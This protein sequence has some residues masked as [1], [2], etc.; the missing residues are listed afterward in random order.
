MVRRFWEGTVLGGY[1]GHGETYMHPDD[2]LWWAKGGTL[3]GTSPERIAFLRRVMEE[4]PMMGMDPVARGWDDTVIGQDGSYY[5]QYFGIKRPSFRKLDYLP[6]GIAFEVDIIDTWEMTIT[7]AEGRYSKG[8]ALM[9]PAKPYIA[10]R[11]RY[12][13]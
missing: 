11:Y 5:L 9:L 3:H 2:I 10:L 13:S 6:E 1:V 12:H 7:R 8:D 4:G